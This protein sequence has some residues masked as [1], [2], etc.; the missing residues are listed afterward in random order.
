MK[1][2]LDYLRVKAVDSRKF[3]AFRL[4]GIAIKKRKNTGL[5]SIAQTHYL[6]WSN[7][8]YFNQI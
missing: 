4:M 1:V 8:Y 6:V 5:N 7:Y 2:D 3:Q